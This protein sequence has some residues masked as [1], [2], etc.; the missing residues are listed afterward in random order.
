[1]MDRRSN[2]AFSKS[3]VAPAVSNLRTISPVAAFS[4]YTMP[5]VPPI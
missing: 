3:S 4:A 1:M 5:S 2:P